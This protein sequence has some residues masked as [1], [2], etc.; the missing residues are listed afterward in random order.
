MQKI[1]DSELVKHAQANQ[2]SAASGVES[3][4]ELY[5]RHHQRI[6]RYL[7]SRVSNRQ[8]AEDL[9]GEVFARMITNLPKYR[10]TQVPFQAWLFRIAHNILIDYY[11]KEGSKKELSLEELGAVVA[12]TDNPARNIEQQQF[13]EQVW[14]ALQELNPSRQEVVTLRFFMG[15]SIQEVASIVGKTVNA[16][17]MTQYRGLKE[18]RQ[19]LERESREAR[20][21]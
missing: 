8:V 18:L 15:F 10:P 21:G 1:S 12:G 9:T 13:S 3:I 4:G 7:W 14:G 19:V 16:V 17:K 11:R 2:S 5:D 20:D 6:F